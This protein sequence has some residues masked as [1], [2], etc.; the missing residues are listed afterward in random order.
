MTMALSSSDPGPSAVAA[1]PPTSLQAR[2]DL[3]QQGCEK[4]LDELLRLAQPRLTRYAERYCEVHDVE[5]AVQETMLAMSRH[6]S[7]LRASGALWAWLFRIVKRECDRM[8]RWFRLHVFDHDP[9]R[10]LPEPVVESMPE[11]RRD[12]A[13]AFAGLPPIYREVLLL[14]EVSQLPLRELSTR[15]DLTLAATKSRLHRARLLVR[16]ALGPV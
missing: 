6:L 7:Q 14:R 15:L 2:V 10:P 3:A 5:D 11:L 8:K 4:S 9:A 1:V 12:L 16:E 13:A